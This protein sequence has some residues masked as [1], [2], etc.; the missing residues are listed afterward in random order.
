MIGKEIESYYINLSFYIKAI[1]CIVN[2]L[3]LAFPTEAKYYLCTCRLL[4]FA[5]L[6]LYNSQLLK[7]VHFHFLI[8]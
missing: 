7:L 2:A 6:N 8:H 5:L 4:L 3:H 1:A